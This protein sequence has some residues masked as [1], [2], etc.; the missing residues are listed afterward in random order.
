[1][2]DACKGN[3]PKEILTV[4]RGICLADATCSKA[5]F[6]QALAA[7]LDEKA[8]TGKYKIPLDDFKLPEYILKAIAHVIPAATTAAD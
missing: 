3:H 5:Q 6:A 7:A 4:W 1:M 2:L 8:A